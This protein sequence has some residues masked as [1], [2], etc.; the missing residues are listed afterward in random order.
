M[1]DVRQVCKK[2]Q[3]RAL[4]TLQTKKI[5]CYVHL[6]QCKNSHICRNV[7]LFEEM[8]SKESKDYKEK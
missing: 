7:E 3:R 8:F 2:I 4:T 1:N 6:I 5:V